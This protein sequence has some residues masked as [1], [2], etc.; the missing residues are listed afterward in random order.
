MGAAQHREEAA[1]EQDAARQHVK[2]YDPHATVASPVRPAG[3]PMSGDYLFP[4][5]VYNPTEVEFGR[6]GDHRAHLIALHLRVKP[7]PPRHH[8]DIGR[9]PLDQQI[10]NAPVDSNVHR[11]LGVEH[12]GG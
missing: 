10:D 2:G 5:A 4:L 1:R 3:G 12:V 7:R 6:A 11:A 9:R 8:A